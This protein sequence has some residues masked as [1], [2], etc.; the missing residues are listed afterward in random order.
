M[1]KDRYKDYKI[2]LTVRAIM[3]WEQLTNKSFFEFGGPATTEEDC[4]YMLYSCFIASNDQVVSF[5]TF[6]ILYGDESFSKWINK[7][8][9]EAM[10]FYRQF[11]RDD[12]EDTDTDEGGSIDQAD[13]KKATITSVASYLIAANHMSADYVT[14]QMELFEMK[15]YLKAIDNAE[16]Q[17]L[18]EERLWC[19]LTIAPHVDTRKI[20]SPQKLLPF[21]WEE[22]EIKKRE[23]DELRAQKDNINRVIGM[24][25]SSLFMHPGTN[26]NTDNTQDDGGD[27]DQ[28][29]DADSVRPSDAEEGDA[30]AERT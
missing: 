2:R 25:L 30:P 12:E 20:K 26:N 10:E 29:G 13:V 3:Y 5:N 27:T 7:A 4:L 15:S 28:R 1:F 21:E 24:D 19:Y 18:I 9:G 17:R 6:K 23:L 8:F 14:N 11:N 16:K 22:A